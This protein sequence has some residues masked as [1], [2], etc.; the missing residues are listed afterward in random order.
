VIVLHSSD[1]VHSVGM[2]IP[3][4]SN[5][6]DRP[7]TTVSSRRGRS[8]S[9][10]SAT[11]LVDSIPQGP[12]VF[13]PKLIIQIPTTFVNPDEFGRSHAL[14]NIEVIRTVDEA[15][16]PTVA[17][18]PKKFSQFKAFHEEW[19]KTYPELAQNYDL[20]PKVWIGNRSPEVMEKRREHLEK[21]IV[22]LSQIACLT[23]FVGDF[24]QMDPEIL[25]QEMKNKRDCLNRAELAK[26]KS[27]RRSFDEAKSRRP[28]PSPV[29]S[30][31]G[32]LGN[33]PVKPRTPSAS[34]AQRKGQIEEK[35]DI[36][37]QDKGPSLPPIP[38]QFLSK[39]ST[40]SIVSSRKSSGT[41]VSS[42]KASSQY[43]EE[44]LQFFEVTHDYEPVH[45]DSMELPMKQGEIL[46]VTT[47]RDK[48][49][50]GW[51][52]GYDANGNKG[53]FPEDFLA[54]TDKTS[55]IEQME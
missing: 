29:A 39:G 24:L 21:Y 38:S 27:V 44:D 40:T 19:S 31:V 33:V 4:A 8:H 51:V 50:E 53:Y 16:K 41:V 47:W 7:L 3:V 1:F 55:P 26:L 2:S 25:K 11:P 52:F 18:I 22:A 12:L 42:R 32:S 49:Y 20:P 14:Y 10:A 45:A 37:Y 6:S 34:H 46:A 54:P 36:L 17:K 30:R 5:H 43:A 13:T 35:K 28:S 15:K 48:E 9:P 23:N